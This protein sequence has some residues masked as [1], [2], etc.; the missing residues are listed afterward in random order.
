MT[1]DQWKKA[2]DYQRKNESLPNTAARYI[3]KKGKYNWNELNAEQYNKH[4]RSTP[5]F[6]KYGKKR[7]SNSKNQILFKH[8][9]YI[10]FWSDINGNLYPTK[11]GRISYRKSKGAHIT[12][13]KPDYLK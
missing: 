12:P 11:N 5:E 13:R 10:G 8:E 4:V 1:F 7:E 9:S 2:V 6:D 3:S